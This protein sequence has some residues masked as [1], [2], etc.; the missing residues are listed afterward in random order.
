MTSKYKDEVC[1]KCG[2]TNDKNMTFHSRKNQ[3]NI[4][5][6]TTDIFLCGECSQAWDKLYKQKE[7][8]FARGDF[9]KTWFD[10][11]F[12]VFIAEKVKVKVILI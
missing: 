6:V 1:F 5:R 11:F 2:K 9:A 3:F 7:G 4:K 12:N 10:L 8:D